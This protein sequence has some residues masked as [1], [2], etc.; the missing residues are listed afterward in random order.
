MSTTY[1]VIGIMVFLLLLLFSAKYF[2]SDKNTK[3]DL[4]VATKETII[5]AS[6][7]PK[8]DA[9]SANFTHSIW[10]Y[11]NDWNHNYG[12]YKPIFGKF[13]LGEGTVT[14]TFE[15][16]ADRTITNATLTGATL[17]VDGND[18]LTS[19][20]ITID[21]TN[22]ITYADATGA[23]VEITAGT[24]S[25]A[26]ILSGAT[27][28][29]ASTTPEIRNAA[30]SIA[31]SVASITSGNEVLSNPI[32]GTSDHNAKKFIEDLVSCKTSVCNHKPSPVVAFAKNDNT[33]LVFLPG[34]NNSVYECQ[35]HNVPLQKWVHVAITLYNKTL[36][37][38]INGKLHKTCVLPQVPLM[39]QGDV[40]I[41]PNGGFDGYTSKYQAFNSALNPQEIW[42]IY[43]NGYGSLASTIG[44]YQLQVSLK[45][46]GS[47]TN[48]FTI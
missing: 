13:A 3:T 37:I 43:T 9:V 7:L 33:I 2:V 19:L 25:G 27:I 31:N 29:S 1:I 44:D 39:E 11:V 28:G 46:N 12:E 34:E 15:L 6:D 45:E 23:S 22:G 5:P 38:Y 36:D 35:V 10:V 30:I 14:S 41:T 47:V 24:I 42:N 21:A 48:S 20:T 4:L 18:D 8:M 32:T 17:S 40:L 16:S 26:T